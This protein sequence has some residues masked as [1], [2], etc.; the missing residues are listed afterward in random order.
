MGRDAWDEPDL[1][2]GMDDHNPAIAAE[3]GPGER[4]VWA[5]QPRVGRLALPAIPLALFGVVFAGF[6]GFWITSVNRQLGGD[7]FALF[8]LP[9]VFIGLAAMLSPGWFVWAASQ[10]RYAV[11]DRRVLLLEPRLGLGVQVRSYEPGAL[12]NIIRTQRGDG[13]GDLIFEEIRTFDHQ[14]HS[15]ITHRGFKGIANVRQ[16][17]ELIRSTLLVDQPRS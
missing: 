4:L 10:T 9:F 6:G 5:G 15:R 1:G 12:T 11:T 13:S 17:E 14:G 2:T 7:G 3:L 16:V 8:G